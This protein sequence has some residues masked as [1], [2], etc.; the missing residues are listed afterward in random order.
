MYIFFIY[1]IPVTVFCLDKI[2]PGTLEPIHRSGKYQRE[3]AGRGKI[4]VA[5]FISVKRW[6][7]NLLY[8]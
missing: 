2:L 3:E 6:I 5:V 4:C 1:N 8:L 7:Y